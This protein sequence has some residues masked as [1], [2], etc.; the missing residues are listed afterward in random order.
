MGVPDIYLNLLTIE[1]KPGL[2]FFFKFC[3]ACN[4]RKDWFIISV[5]QTW[6]VNMKRFE[7][8][9]TIISIG[10]ENLPARII[11]QRFLSRQSHWGPER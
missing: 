6:Y 8:K 1:Y 10:L 9:I 5:L 4:G 7:S 2:D 3:E 11:D